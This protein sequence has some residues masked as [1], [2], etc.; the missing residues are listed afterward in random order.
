MKIL[1]TILFAMMAVVTSVAFMFASYEMVTFVKEKIARMREKNN[2]E[3]I[4]EDGE[5]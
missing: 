3:D 4:S 1:K 5:L 2:L